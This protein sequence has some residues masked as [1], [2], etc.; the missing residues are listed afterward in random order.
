M[1]YSIEFVDGQVPD[2]LVSVE[3]PMTVEGNRAWLAELIGDARWR[4]GMK[5]LVDGT[6]LE[7]AA[8]GGDDVREVAETT[9]S[10]ADVWG[11]GSS[12]VV[13]QDPAVYGLLRIWQAMTVDMEWRTEIFYSREEAIA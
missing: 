6:G 12:A 10:E 4:P 7:P 1:L 8:F 9:A 5:T 13:V 2:A 11:P 3:G